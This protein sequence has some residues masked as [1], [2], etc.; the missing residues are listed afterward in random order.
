MHLELLTGIDR[1]LAAEIVPGNQLAYADTILFGDQPEVFAFL[2]LV[3]PRTGRRCRGNSPMHLELLTGIDRTLAAEVVPGN[4]F[5]YADTV[6]FGDQPKVFTPSY[7]MVNYRRRFG[8]ATGRRSRS[9]ENLELL[10]GEN[11]RVLQII[12]LNKLA[13]IAAVHSCYRCKGFT[14]TDNMNIF[15]CRNRSYPNFTRFLQQSKPVSHLLRLMGIDLFFLADK[16][17]YIP[18][19]NSQII[20]IT[21]IS[22]HKT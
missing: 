8:T 22:R 9:P 14:T 17:F 12:P 4:Q 2:H 21:S 6:L 10:T 5:A 13:D 11:P 19:R 7:L 3:R 16:F 20:R 18:L 1:T 15:L